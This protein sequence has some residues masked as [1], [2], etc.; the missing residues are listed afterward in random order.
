M[1]VLRVTNFE[2]EFGIRDPDAHTL[3]F[4]KQRAG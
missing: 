4:S 2:R 1:P 3:A